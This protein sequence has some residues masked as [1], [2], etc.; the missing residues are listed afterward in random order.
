MPTPPLDSETTPRGPQPDEFRLREFQELRATIRQR[1][2]VRVIVSVLTFVS[3]AALVIA[4]FDHPLPP[5]CLVPLFVLAAGFEAVYAVHTGAERIGRYLL[6]FYERQAEMPKW[7][8]AIAAFG[9]TEAARAIGGSALF[10][11]AFLLAA[12]LNLAATYAVL[13]GGPRSFA[14]LTAVTALTGAH[15]AFVVRLLAARAKARR[16]RELDTAAFRAIE[17]ELKTH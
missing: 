3:W 5:L 12:G 7:E 4:A 11:P 10:A 15:A 1:G 17:A 16:Q 9:R 13:P 14:D 8:T 2:H 6:V